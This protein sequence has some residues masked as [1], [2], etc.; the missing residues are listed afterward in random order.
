MRIFLDLPVVFHKGRSTLHAFWRYFIDGNPKKSY[1]TFSVAL[2]WIFPRHKDFLFVFRCC[3]L[4]LCFLLLCFLAAM[5]L[6]YCCCCC[7]CGSF[8]FWVCW[9]CCTCSWY[10]CCCCSS[11][12]LLI[13][14]QQLL[15]LLMLL[16][17]Q[18]WDTSWVISCCW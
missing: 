6:N 8:K 13:F 1:I 9:F 7:C 15:R 14:F 18:I 2:I 10:W 4:L 11:I 16:M 3:L 5:T 12:I 17:M